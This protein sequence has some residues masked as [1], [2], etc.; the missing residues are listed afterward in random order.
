MRDIKFRVWDSFEKEYEYSDL[1]ACTSIDIMTITPSEGLTIEQYTG[2]KDSNG[3]E[4]FEG[5][6]V[7][8]N[9]VMLE[10]EVR[11]HKGGFW[12][13]NKEEDRMGLL[14]LFKASKVIGNIHEGVKAND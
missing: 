9:G 6:I 8:D 13:F 12:C 11:Y 3:K 4:I 1:L 10:F 7:Y 2:L 14:G 5:D